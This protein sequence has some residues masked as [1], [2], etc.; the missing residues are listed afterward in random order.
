MVTRT[1][2]NRAS[3][4]PPQRQGPVPWPRARCVVR[5]KII[6]MDATVWT[7][8]GAAIAILA[9]V[10]AAFRSLRDETRAQ[11]KELRGRIDAQ[12]RELREQIDAQGHYLREQVGQLR[13]R[14]AHLEGLL[15][16]LREAIT[17]RV[18]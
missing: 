7:L 14:L 12:G 17:K 15:E 5:G 1:S 13:E 16:G 2:R 3:R 9:A 8:V 18:A 4:P 10:G 11:G 6:H